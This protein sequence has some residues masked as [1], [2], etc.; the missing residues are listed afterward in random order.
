MPLEVAQKFIDMLLENDK[1]TQQYIDTRHSDAIIL[2]F[3]GGE[4]FLEVE[5]I[6]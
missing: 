1:N 2:E 4:P 5:L 6:D 3:I